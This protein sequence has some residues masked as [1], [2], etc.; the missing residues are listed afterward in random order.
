MRF[1]NTLLYKT[2]MQPVDFAQESCF[3]SFILASPLILSWLVIAIPI[4]V[5]LDILSSYKAFLDT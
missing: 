2:V 5:L 4:S 1:K 3:Y